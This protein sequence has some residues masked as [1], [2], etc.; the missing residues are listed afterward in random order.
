MLSILLTRLVRPSLLLR[1]TCPNLSKIFWYTLSLT[2]FSRPLCIS[3]FQFSVCPAWSLRANSSD[4][5]SIPSSLSGS[6]FLI[7]KV[8]VPKI[9][10]CVAH[11]LKRINSAGTKE[12]W[13][14][15]QVK[16]STKIATEVTAVCHTTLFSH[17]SL[18]SKRYTLS[19]FD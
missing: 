18:H 8:S 13:K 4:F 6:S 19:L 17:Q 2:F 1:C 5:H 16:R 12:V 11:L 7:P 3:C 15:S 10:A 9:I 14:L